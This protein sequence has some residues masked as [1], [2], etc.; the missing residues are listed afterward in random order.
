MIIL[1]LI[2]GNTVSIP[3]LK[4]L[5]LAFIYLPLLSLPIIIALKL[6]RKVCSKCTMCKTII[7]EEE[8]TYTVPSPIITRGSDSQITHTSVELHKPLLN[9][10]CD[11]T[12]QSELTTEI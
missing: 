9:K 2:K 10:E 7:G 4:L 5:Q 1:C 11:Y 6:G 8:Q 12:L 3:K